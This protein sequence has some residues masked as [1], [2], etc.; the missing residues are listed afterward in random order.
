MVG[1]TVNELGPCCRS[2]ETECSFFVSDRELENRMDDEGTIVVQPENSRDEEWGC[3]E[4]NRTEL[5]RLDL[6]M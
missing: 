4:P 6:D 2:I 1:C 5:G 3:V